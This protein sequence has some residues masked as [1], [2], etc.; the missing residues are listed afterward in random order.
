[1][2]G[3]RGGRGTWALWARSPAASRYYPP[4]RT[5]GPTGRRRRIFSW[6]TMVIV[7]V[8]VMIIVMVIVMVITA[9]VLALRPVVSPCLIMVHLADSV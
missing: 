9:P 3:S 2:E 8:I 1:M 6:A 5:T 7:M 4:A